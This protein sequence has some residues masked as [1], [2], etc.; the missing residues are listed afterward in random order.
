VPDCWKDPSK[1]PNNPREI[2]DGPRELTPDQEKQRTAGWPGL[3]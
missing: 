1:V 3:W 2:A